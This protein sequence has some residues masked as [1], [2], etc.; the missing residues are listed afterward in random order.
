MNYWAA[1]HGQGLVL[2]E[3]EFHAF[4]KNYEEK[5]RNND[6]LDEIGKYKAGDIGLNAINFVTGAGRKFSIFPVE[7][8]DMEGFRLTPYRVDGKP[9]IDWDINESIPFNNVYV[10][11]ADKAIDGMDCFEKKA[12][13]SYEQFVEEFKDKMDGCLPAGFD[14]DSHIGIYSYACFA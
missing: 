12:Y 1:Y 3:Q 7:D 9:N 6:L 10:V 13:E 4:L 11:T 2:S 14:W 5:C 8:G